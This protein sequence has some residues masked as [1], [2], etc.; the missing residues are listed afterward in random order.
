MMT[1]TRF[2]VRRTALVF[3]LTVLLLSACTANTDSTDERGLRPH[4]SV[5]LWLPQQLSPGSA[6]QFR[7][8]IQ[9]G[10]SPVR[11][12]SVIFEF[13]PEDRPDQIVSVTGISEGEGLYSAEHRLNREGLYVVRCLVAAGSLEAMPAK[14]LAIGEA[15]VLRLAA[16]ERQ[17]AADAT[18]AGAS[19]GHH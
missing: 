8:A 19:G 12:D 3:L 18:Q 10:E 13:W 6:G 5:D 7:I 15:A 2:P 16:L 1:Q 17:S 4:L 9:Q 14:R 11:A